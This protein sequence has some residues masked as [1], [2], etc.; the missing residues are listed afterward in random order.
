MPRRTGSSSYFPPLWLFALTALVLVAFAQVAWTPEAA[1]EAPERPLL[2]QTLDGK[3]VDLR[4]LMAG[5]PTMLIFWATWCPTCRAEVPDF[6]GAYH[7][8]SRKGLQVL[9]VDVG[10]N[11]P[12]E[13]VRQFSKARALPYTVLYDARQKAVQA[14]GVVGTPTVLLLAPDGSVVSRGY[15]VD[16]AAI[17]HLLATRQS[18]AK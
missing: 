2:V 8:Y 1:T 11:D 13:D 7:R 18:K 10:Y 4:A 12:I 14:Y 9:A 17:E 15:G 3:T 16:D 5:K 6:A